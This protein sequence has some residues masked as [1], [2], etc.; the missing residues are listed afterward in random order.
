MSTAAVRDVVRQIGQDDPPSDASLLA[1]YL[2]SRDHA[3][4]AELLRRYGPVVFGVCRRLLA[5]RHDA[6]DAFQA[7]FL[8][9]VRKAESVQPPG[10]VGNWLYGVAVRTAN[11]AKLAAARRWRREMARAMNDPAASEPISQA[12]LSELRGVIDE[13]LARLPDRLRAAVVLCDLGGKSRREA[14]RELACPE[15]TVAARLHRARKLLAERFTKRGIALSS[16][17]LAAAFTPELATANVSSELARKTLATTVGIASASPAVQTLAS[18]VMRTMSHGKFKMMFAVVAVAGLMTGA[19]AIWGAS[20]TD[21]RPMTGE[22]TEATAPPADPAPK[23]NA[24][25][26]V[27]DIQFSPD[28]D[29]YAVVAGRK[30]TFY[31]TATQ[32]KLSFHVPGGVP[33]AWKAGEAARFVKYPA[34]PKFLRFKNPGDPGA[35]FVEEQTPPHTTLKVMEAKGPTEYSTRQVVFPASDSKPRPKTTLGWHFV[36]FSP[37]GKH[38]AAHFGFNV[39]VYDTATGFEPVRL[40]NQ[41]E[42]GST[43]LSATTGKQ[44][45]WSPDGKRLAAVGVLVGEG[46]MG[47]A[48]WDAETGKRLQA[49][50]SYFLDGPRSVAFSPDGDH[51]AIGFKDCVQ[52]WVIRGDAKKNSVR[53]YRTAGP[54]TALAYSVDAKWIAVGRLGEVRVLNAESGD[55]S[56]RF[57]GFEESENMQK[58]REAEAKLRHSRRLLTDPTLTFAQKL[59]LSIEAELAQETIDRAKKLFKNSLPVTALAFSPNGKTLLAGTGILP[60]EAIPEGA[61]KSGEV[62]TFSLEVAAP[63]PWRQKAVLTDNEDSIIS[64]AFAPD[65]KTFAA[66]GAR[67]GRVAVWDATTHKRLEWFSYSDIRPHPAVVAYSPDS[68]TLAVTIKDGAFL[69]DRISGEK[70]ILVEEKGSN[71]RSVAFIPDRPNKGGFIAHGVILGTGSK[72]FLKT[73]VELPKASTIEFA[74]LPEVVGPSPLAIAPDG[75]RAI[76][77]RNEFK[78]GK[79]IVWAW[80]LGSGS[81]N[82]LLIGHTDVVYAAAW[83][84]DGKLVATAGADGNVILWDGT[85]FKEMR[86]LTADQ[87]ATSVAI[88]PDSKWVAAGTRK[89]K[90]DGQLEGTTTTAVSVRIWEAATGREVQQLTGF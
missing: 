19:G 64:V 70:G 35:G 16:S 41:H 18:G 89:E 12:E 74:G 46:K 51:L 17:G 66:G 36:S 77:T 3:A 72:Y 5:N 30:V 87:R 79:R 55:E 9:L 68:K 53:T 22:S 49:I 90:P 71:P 6:E 57:A 31:D 60:L 50:E 27:T 39:R 21:S 52:V 13:E 84:K 8:V 63:G 4:F 42:P 11:K 85:S 75:S 24:T 7:V 86:K 67:R 81:T 32:K 37:D 25:A 82:E 38:Y 76:V 48:V 43:A 62:K 1:R 20:A 2:E 88:S 34:G 15:G 29:M 45:V 14:A 10:L 80:S 61:P 58:L 69:L 47:A 73:W 44:L 59:Q 33:E 65:G 56:W 23:S 26:Y 54:V 28:G 78:D 40:D 83:S